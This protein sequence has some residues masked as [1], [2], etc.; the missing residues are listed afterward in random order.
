MD[1]EQGGIYVAASEAKFHAQSRCATRQLVT[2]KEEMIYLF[3]KRL[4]SEL[5]VLSIHMIYAERSFNEVTNYVKKVEGV[6]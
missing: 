5:H 1:L 4:N 2:T 3:I 6:R